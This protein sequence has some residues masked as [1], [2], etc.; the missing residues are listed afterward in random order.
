[1]GAPDPATTEAW[2]GTVA[3]PEGQEAFNKM[4]GS[5]P[6]NTEAD[7]SDFGAYQQTAIESYANDEIV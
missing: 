4:K 6:A 1:V 7:T 5:I 3:S 2:L